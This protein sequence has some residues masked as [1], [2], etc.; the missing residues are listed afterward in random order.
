MAQIQN[1][2]GWMTSFF[3]EQDLTSQYMNGVLNSGL[4]PGI[5]NPNICLYTR[6]STTDVRLP[7]DQN[8]INLFIKKGTTFIF[9]N[10]YEKKGEVFQRNLNNV[11]TYLIKCFAMEDIIYPLIPVV[12]ATP[13]VQETLG[14]SSEPVSEKDRFYVVATI[15]YDPEAETNITAPQFE[16]VKI[17][18]VEGTDKRR[19][20]ILGSSDYLPGGTEEL[21]TNDSKISYLFLGAVQSISKEGY[22]VADTGGWKPATTGNTSTGDILWGKHHVFMGRG[23]PEY[24]QTLSA[25]KFIPSPELML[26][27]E[28]TEFRLDMKDT[29]V[30]D[31][32]VNKEYSYE[33]NYEILE[34]SD[35][36][37]ALSS[38]LA[39]VDNTNNSIP[40]PYD[41]NKLVQDIYFLATRSRYSEGVSRENLNGESF[42]ENVNYEIVHTAIASAIENLNTSSINPS[43]EKIEDSSTTSASSNCAHPSYTTSDDSASHLRGRKLIPLD[44]NS[45]NRDRLLGYIRNKTTLPKVINYLRGNNGLNVEQETTLTPLAIAFRGIKTGSGDPVSLDDISTAGVTGTLARVHP[46]NVLSFLDLQFKSSKINTIMA[47]SRDIYSI[48]PIQ[49]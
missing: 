13:K 3:Y 26:S 33:A 43:Y 47:N 32:L 42:T 5:Y 31:I 45:V 34:N 23:F 41:G 28:L 19:F 11:G 15:T 25:D 10:N 6:G 44:V 7:K 8:G 27:P 1:N 37:S 18:A 17:E 22:Y 12:N 48:L 46:C 2:S 24:R 39:I 38:N 16:C 4:K 36:T 49:D 29:L 20:K 30:D 21:G 9:S 14:T 35:T 40:G